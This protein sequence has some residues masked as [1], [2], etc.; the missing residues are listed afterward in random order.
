MNIVLK[1]AAE[2]GSISVT[3]G[4]YDSQMA[5]VPNLEG[6]YA[7]TNGDFAFNVGGDREANDGST[8]TISANSGFD[9]REQYNRLDN[10]SVNSG[11]MS[12]QVTNAELASENKTLAHPASINSLPTSTNQ[13]DHLSIATFAGRRL[14]D[15]FDNVA[16]ILGIEW[17]A[18]SQGLEIRVTLETTDKLKSVKA[19]LRT[20]VSFYDKGRYFHQILRMPKH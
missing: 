6:A 14:W 2:G 5:G 18:A 12:A 20:K 13:E 16:G 1:D 17:L 10:G 7:D 4:K 11:F 8:R 19:L 3:Y 9:P 15:I